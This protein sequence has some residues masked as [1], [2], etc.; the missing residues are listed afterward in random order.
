MDKDIAVPLAST[1]ISR[2]FRATPRFRTVPRALPWASISR[3]FSEQYP[4]LPP[5]RK[6]SQPGIFKLKTL[7]HGQPH[8][9]KT[10]PR[11]RYFLA[12]STLRMAP[13]GTT[14]WVLLPSFFWRAVNARFPF[15]DDDEYIR[16]SLRVQA[17]LP[18]PSRLQSGGIGKA[19]FRQ[20]S[21]HTLFRSCVGSPPGR[22]FLRVPGLGNDGFAGSI[23]LFQAN[24]PVTA[25]RLSPRLA[26]WPF[27]IRRGCAP[28]RRSWRPPA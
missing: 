25:E 6:T 23:S 12:F 16:G 28:R 22:W 13:S 24:M 9:E 15:P 7:R 10:K 14:I 5:A 8:A 17:S 21:A 19:R 18:S 26:G 2:L 27:S 20:A 1:P 3:P 4:P 11:K